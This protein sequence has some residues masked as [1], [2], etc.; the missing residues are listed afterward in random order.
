M[1]DDGI[2]LLDETSAIGFQQIEADDYLE[3]PERWA[4]ETS[5]SVLEVLG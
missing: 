3:A 5:R 1:P 2:T 4:R